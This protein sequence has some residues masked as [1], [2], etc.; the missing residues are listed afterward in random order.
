[1][2]NRGEPGVT[3]RDL[4]DEPN[5]RR[6]GAEGPSDLSRLIMRLAQVVN[7]KRN[8]NVL[9]PAYRRM[10]GSE[11]LTIHEMKLIAEVPCECAICAKRRAAGRPPILPSLPSEENWS[12]FDPELEPSSVADPELGSALDGE[13]GDMPF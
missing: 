5:I 12:D 7:D 3:I 6:D 2:F 8:L 4:T 1:M 11:P 9:M 13:E 10:Q